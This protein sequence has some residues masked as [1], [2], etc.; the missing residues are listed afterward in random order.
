MSVHK[1][2]AIDQ[3]VVQAVIRKKKK[4]IQ[5]TDDNVVI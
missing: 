4:K 2:P 5:I 3:L 1:F